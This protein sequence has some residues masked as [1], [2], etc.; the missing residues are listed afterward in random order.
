M[1]VLITGDRNWTDKE[2]IRSWLSKLQ[3]F[4]YTEVIEGGAKGVDTIAREEALRMH[5]N[6][7]H[8]PAQWDRYGKAAGPIRNRTMLDQQPRLVLAFHHD[9]SESKGTKDC[10]AE[11]KRRGI[12]VI[13]EAGNKQ[14]G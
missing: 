9:I 14:G 2:T 7:Q 6:V 11:A 4:G 5:F 10:V 3:D 12:T 13:I 8:F 1:K